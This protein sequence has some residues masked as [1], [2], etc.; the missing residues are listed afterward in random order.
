M[1]KSSILNGT[2]PI[3]CPALATENKSE[4]I[5]TSAI[6]PFHEPPNFVGLDGVVRRKPSLSQNGFALQQVRSA[7]SIVLRI[8]TT[9]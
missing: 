5:P 3:A 7:Q 6:L 8:P 9:P 4:T 1:E 2:P